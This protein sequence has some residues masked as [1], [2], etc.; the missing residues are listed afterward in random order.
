M[1]LGADE[2]GLSLREGNGDRQHLLQEGGQKPDFCPAQSCTSLSHR[3]M[4]NVFNVLRTMF[5]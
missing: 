3:L 5:L 1:P 2:P 4:L